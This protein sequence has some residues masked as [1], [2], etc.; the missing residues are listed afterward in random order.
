VRLELTVLEDRCLPSGVV[1][2]LVFQDFNA[3]GVRD[4]TATI[5]NGGSG[6][7]GVAV[8]RGIGGVRVTGY[9]P[10]GKVRGSTVSA[11]DGTYTLDLAGTGPYR[12]EFSR[13]PAGFFAGPQGPDNG[14]TVQF[15]PDGDSSGVDL[16]VVRPTD[17][18]PDN[19]LLVTSTYVFGDQ[20]NGDNANQPVIVSF[21]YSSGASDATLTQAPYRQ[22]A[23]HALSVAAR[24]VGSTWGLAYNRFTQT[25]YAAAFMKKYSG[26]GPL[27]NGGIYQMGTT[28]TTAEPFADLNRI[29]GQINDGP[30]FR[31][32]TMLT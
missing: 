22:P 29:F 6:S 2:G 21:P 12:V 26:F 16:G 14:T 5:P 20:I 8:D 13:L 30:D 17:Y 23:G 31:V 1:T 15:V 4:T 32:N 24:F 10:A 25:L 19:P 28:G 27:G 18:S 3:N 11:A 7:I 9:D